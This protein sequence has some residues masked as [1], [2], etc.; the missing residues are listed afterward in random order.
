MYTILT[1]ILPQ[2]GHVTNDNATN[3][4]TAAEEL[5]KRM[6]A[7]GTVGNW[8]AGKRKLGYVTMRLDMSRRTTN[9]PSDVLVT[10][11]S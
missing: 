5:E 9:N 1:R 8:E 2:L 11:F 3:N 7:R 6:V 4:D 10:S